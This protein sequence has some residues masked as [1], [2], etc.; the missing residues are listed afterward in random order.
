[1]NTRFDIVIA[2]AGPAGLCLAVA[3]ASRTLRVAVIDPQPRDA[4]A[5]PGFDGREIALTHTSVST[6]GQLGLWSRIAPEEVS[7]IRDLRVFNGA[8]ARPMH[9]DHSDGGAG[10]LGHLVSNHLIRRAAYE[11]ASQR[12][13]VAIVTEAAVCGGRDGGPLHGPPLRSGGRRSGGNASGHRA[14]LQ[15]GPADPLG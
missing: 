2:G 7:A 15:P 9:I 8:S 6:L 1:M 4:L 12:E 10:E 11:A 3:L 5:A 13:R 14:W